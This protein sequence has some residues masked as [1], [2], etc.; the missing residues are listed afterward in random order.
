MVLAPRLFPISFNTDL[1]WL[2]VAFALAISFASSLVFGFVPALR[3]SNVDLAGV[4]KDDLSPRGGSRGRLRSTL[5][6]AQVAV[7]LL[8][9]VGAGLVVRSLEAA[10]TA[11]VGF[12]ERHVAVAMIDLRSSGYDEESGRVF[13]ERILDTLRAQPGHESVS[14]AS[15]AAVDAR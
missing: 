14:L 2:V 8:L 10:R 3:S 1:D 12:D 15:W 4:M 7:A 11:N 9:L 13:Y 6:V 5:V